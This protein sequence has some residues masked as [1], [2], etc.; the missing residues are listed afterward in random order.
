MAP[1]RSHVWKLPPWCMDTASAAC[2]LL[3]LVSATS[4]QVRGTLASVVPLSSGGFAGCIGRWHRVS[5]G[6][7]QHIMHRRC[8][9]APT[10][11]QH[12]GLF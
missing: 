3:L 7:G 2:C 11:K 10:R 5:A 12:C 4:G 1:Q 9:G 8:V 6:P